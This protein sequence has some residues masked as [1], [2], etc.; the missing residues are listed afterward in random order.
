M[1]IYEG[2]YN[3]DTLLS[4]IEKRN[5]RK[6]ANQEASYKAK[7]D[8][9]KS[10]NSGLPRLLEKVKN[11]ITTDGSSINDAV[12]DTLTPQVRGNPEAQLQ[13]IEIDSQNEQNKY[14]LG[15]Y[16]GQIEN[17]YNFIKGFEPDS[18]EFDD[19]TTQSS[20]VMTDPSKIADYKWKNMT[21]QDIKDF[22]LFSDGFFSTMYEDPFAEQPKA[23]KFVNSYAHGGMRDMDIINKMEAIKKEFETAAFAMLENGIID[24]HEL[25]YIKTGN[26]SALD[27]AQKKNMNDS[28]S[29]AESIISSMNSIKSYQKT[30][31]NTIGKENWNTGEFD[32]SDWSTIEEGT[33]RN[34]AKVHMAKDPDVYSDEQ[35]AVDDFASKLMGMS[36]ADVYELWDSEIAFL[37]LALEKEQNKYYKWGGT[38]LT[39]GGSS[40]KTLD[41]E[42]KRLQSIINK[43][44][45]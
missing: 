33:R 24:Q 19:P 12:I 28:K 7:Q 35:H 23:N 14:D 34:I 2:H 31:L 6:Q 4:V 40:D 3:L 17:A 15:N 45:N 44:N 11:T 39:V 38:E 41:V 1:G 32:I 36:Y 22:E 26:K 9:S 10:L 25:M 16:K 29:A 21:V 8:A 30:M 13:L 5:E 42:K 37:K 27:T 18:L 20:V 43:Q